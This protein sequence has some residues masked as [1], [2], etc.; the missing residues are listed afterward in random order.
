MDHVRLRHPSV[1]AAHFHQEPA[2]AYQSKYPEG[3]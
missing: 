3:D 2:T 1:T